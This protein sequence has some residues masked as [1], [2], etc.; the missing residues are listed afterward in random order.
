LQEG[1]AVDG[2]GGQERRAAADDIAR[3]RAL[4]DRLPEIGPEDGVF[5]AKVAAIAEGAGRMIGEIS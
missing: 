4:E 5:S 1:R 2:D 3:K